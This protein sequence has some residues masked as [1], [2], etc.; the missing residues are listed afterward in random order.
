MCFYHLGVALVRSILSFGSFAVLREIWPVSPLGEISVFY[1]GYRCDMGGYHLDITFVWFVSIFGF[2][3]VFEKCR[4]LRWFLRLPVFRVFEKLEFWLQIFVAFIMIYMMDENIIYFHFS[5]FSQD[6][7]VAN[8]DL[9]SFRFWRLVSFYL[10]RTSSPHW[11][12][13]LLTQMG[14]MGWYISDFSTWEWWREF[15][16]VTCLIFKFTFALVFALYFS[17]SLHCLAPNLWAALSL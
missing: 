3:A 13:S 2:S 12:P 14:P 4:Q 10:I 5:L 9:A 15:W 1:T 11:W 6:L 16:L 8:S 17:L 7:K